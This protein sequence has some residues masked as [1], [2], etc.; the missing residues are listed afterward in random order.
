MHSGCTADAGQ[1]LQALEGAGW[2]K[3]GAGSDK[4]VSDTGNQIQLKQQAE[5]SRCTGRGWQQDIRQEAGIAE[6]KQ[7][8]VRTGDSNEVRQARSIQESIQAQEQNSK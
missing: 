3:T 7:A 4:P 8:G 2:A 5:S 1:R 6:S